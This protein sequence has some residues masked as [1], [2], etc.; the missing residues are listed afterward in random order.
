MGPVDD[1][2]AMEWWLDGDSAGAYSRLA[3]KQSLSWAKVSMAGE[4]SM[5]ASAR[6]V[7]ASWQASR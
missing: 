4:G 1:D 3:R 5:Q 6:T 7:S 2:V